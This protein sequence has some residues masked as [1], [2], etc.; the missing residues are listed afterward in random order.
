[1][2]K[3]F[4][5]YYVFNCKNRELCRRLS[6]LLFSS[7]DEVFMRKRVLKDSFFRWG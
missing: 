2:A 1:M 6:H 7:G 4:L 3:Y 5:F